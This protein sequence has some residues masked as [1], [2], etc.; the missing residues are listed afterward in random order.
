VSSSSIT[1]YSDQVIHGE[2]YPHIDGIRAIAVLPV[3][4]FHILAALCPGGFVGVD[5]FFVISGYLITG[6]I[7]RDLKKDR[8]TIRGFYH[9]RIRR[10]MPAYFA[11]IAGVFAVGCALYYAQPLILLGDAVTAGTLFVANLHFWMMGGDYFAPNLHSQALLHLW[12]LSVE[13][14]FYLVI[15]LLCA[16]IWKFNRR[17][18][19]PVL[20]LL[21][22]LSLIGAIYAVLHGKQNN[23]FYLLHYRAWELLAG[24]LLA[25]LPAAGHMSDTSEPR[26]K[27]LKTQKTPAFL[28]ALGLL[29]VGLTYILVSSKTPFPGLAALPPVIGT[30]L[31]IRYGQSGWVARL[32]HCGPFNA[33]GKMSYS[34]YL[35][36]WP[37]AVFWKYAVYDQLYYY[38]YLGMFVLSLLL[39]YLSWKFVEMPV[40]A[41]PSWT[42]R[43]SFTFAVSGI[44]VL[45]TLGSA[46]VYCKGWPTTLHRRANEVAST[47]EIRDPF[48][49]ARTF[50]IVR[51]LGSVANHDFKFAIR[52]SFDMFQ[53]GGDGSAVI[54]STGQPRG[55]L[56]GDSHAG[57]LRYGL[58]NIL[59]KNN[60]A[61]Y[62]ISCSGT[63]M[64][65]LNL[66]ES[67]AA[68]KKL[69]E[70]HQ[71]KW[72]I[73]AEMWSR[74]LAVQNQSQEF[75]YERLI[76]YATQVKAMNKTL[77]IVTDIASYPYVAQEIEVKSRI[78]GLPRGRDILLKS[79]QQSQVDYDQKQGEINRKLEEVC[80]K[81]GAVLIPLHLALKLNDS[82]I[83]CEV[84]DGRYVPLYRDTNHLSMEGSMRAAQFIMS[85][86]FPDA[87]FEK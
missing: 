80:N 52:P 46:C 39:A 4:L 74:S 33:M 79:R 84:K 44:V 49:I 85:Y 57:S 65:N 45:V 2:Y 53:G 69:A 26:L 12:S 59:K 40:R 42:M 51:R 47:P 38:D 22:G 60:L 18:V 7:L 21:A 81:T 9:R 16:I 43:R 17:L 62:A 58:D 54:G 76:E 34:L 37:V 87:V 24:S 8:F 6:G 86:L 78:V 5:V 72:V 23:A 3:V 31:L 11:M 10:I 67:Q 13:E 82:Y 55:L 61:G 64:F 66:S 32:L 50:G 77:Y 68:L 20:V 75:V 56:L 63:D 29:M 36:H 83:S 14:Q 70:L 35:W 19:A 41:S 48:L 71:V 27:T 1:N 15:P 25:M 28:A 30:A 73:L